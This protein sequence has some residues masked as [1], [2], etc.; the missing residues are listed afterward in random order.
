MRDRHSMG[1]LQVLLRAAEQRKR[2]AISLPMGDRR[3]LVLLDSELSARLLSDHASSTVKGPGQQITKKTLGDGLLTSEGPAHDRARRL[4]APAFS[5]R[6]L[7][8]YTAIFAGCAQDS[9]A[10]WRDGEL[11]DMHAEMTGLSLRI[12]GRALLG[13]DL[14][15]LAPWVRDGVEAEF[16]TFAGDNTRDSVTAGDFGERRAMLHRLVDDIIAQHQ[17]QRPG[18][19]GDVISALL[20]VAAEPGGFTSQEVHDHVIT[21]LMAG[22]ET[23]ASALTWTAYLLARHPDVQE[24]LQAEADTLGGRPPSTG[25]LPSLAYTR[26]VFS[27]TIRLYPPAW[28]LDRTACAD[29]EIGDI[30]LRTGS[31]V[32]VSPLL[33][34]RD[35]RWYPDPERF[36]PGRWLGQRPALPRHVY[37][38]FGIGPRACI[39][40]QFAVAEAV[41]VL[42]TLAQSWTFRAAPD[43]EPDVSYLVSLRPAAGM[44]LTCHAR[45]TVSR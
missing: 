23:T 9:A 33:L 43:F 42:A 28:I 27:E 40:E 13:V 32:A 18:D 12:A 21:L 15:E 30:R 45:R 5:P 19:R 39:G 22:H 34:H 29:F 4:V 8:A 17:A 38:P 24:R 3:V 35:P 26:A 44:P 6:R 31:V 16:A 36:D 7:S 14:W 11:R 25:D 41:T 10:G 2:G 37:L 1:T 20:A